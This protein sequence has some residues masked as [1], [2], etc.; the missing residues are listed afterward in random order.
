MYGTPNC[1]SLMLPWCA[2]TSTSLLNLQRPQFAVRTG[3]RAAAR[4]G[5]KGRYG[6]GGQPWRRL[7]PCSGPRAHAGRGTGG[8]GC[9]RRWC[10]DRQFRSSGS[11]TVPRSEPHREPGERARATSPGAAGR[12]AQPADMQPA[13][14][15]GARAAAARAGPSGTL[16]SSQPMPPAPTTSTR[17]PA[18]AHAGSARHTH[19]YYPSVACHT[20]RTRP[21]PLPPPHAARLAE[22][23]CVARAQTTAEAQRR[24]GGRARQ[25]PA[26]VYTPSIYAPVSFRLDV[27]DHSP[28]ALARC[29]SLSAILAGEMLAHEGRLCSRV[30]GSRGV[31]CTG[32]SAALVARW[33]GAPRAGAKLPPAQRPGAGAGRGRGWSGPST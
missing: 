1:L 20:L 9:S 16:S 17:E 29:A 23:A 32:V 28:N 24:R 33:T 18:T 4:A 26:R 19:C 22:H 8:S 12:R 30:G 2:L 3:A 5:G 25:A 31:W 6:T 11:R 13:V 14:W 21:P 7:R 10:P 27:F 15:G